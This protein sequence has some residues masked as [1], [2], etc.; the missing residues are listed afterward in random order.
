MGYLFI[1]TKIYHDIR[2]SDVLISV[3]KIFIYFFYFLFRYSYRLENVEKWIQSVCLVW[4]YGD[5]VYKLRVIWFLEIIEVECC[6]CV[7]WL[8]LARLSF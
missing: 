5:L 3:C 2:W 1:D 7:L 6:V 8:D 4:I